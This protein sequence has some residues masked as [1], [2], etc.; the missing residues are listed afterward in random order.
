MVGYELTGRIR[1]TSYV[2]RTI[3]IAKSDLRYKSFSR[4]D[5][6]AQLR[7]PIVDSEHK[8]FVEQQLRAKMF[9][10][11]PKIFTHFKA[12]S[13]MKRK[14]LRSL[15]VRSLSEGDVAFKKKK[16]RLRHEA[17]E[18]P[19]EKWSRTKKKK[20]T[21]SPLGSCRLISTKTLVLPQ[22]LTV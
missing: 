20:N 7:Y 10:T 22:N 15:N 11:L 2:E 12:T 13:S 18:E 17:Y 8:L 4:I 16:K 1:T 19:V 5:V 14:L 21:F 6:M 3:G 9:K